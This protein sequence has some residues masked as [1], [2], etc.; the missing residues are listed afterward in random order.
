MAYQ[1]L[2]GSVASE[3]LLGELVKQ[4]DRLEARMRRTAKAKPLRHHESAPE[5]GGYCHK[6]CDSGSHTII[7]TQPAHEPRTKKDLAV[8]GGGE[9]AE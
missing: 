5:E 2:K 6:D 9:T 7:G 8:Y 4:S 3:G 1:W